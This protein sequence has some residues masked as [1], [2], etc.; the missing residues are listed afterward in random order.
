MSDTEIYDERDLTYSQWHRI[1]SIKRFVGEKN[2]RLLAMIDIDVTIYVEYED[3]TK[4]PICLIEIARDIGQVN[5]PS[6]VTRKLA[7]KANIYA[8]TVLYTVS[9]TAKNPAAEQ[10]HDVEHLRVKQ[11]YPNKTSWKEL[12]PAEWAN[13][14][15]NM[16]KNVNLL[17][18]NRKENQR[19]LTEWL[20]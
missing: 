13:V 12:S 20:T 8:F 17:S 10:W 4:E 19:Q 18:L 9:K 5:K 1:N 16:R 14:L 6:T 2:A 3:S 7:E 15:L 11:I